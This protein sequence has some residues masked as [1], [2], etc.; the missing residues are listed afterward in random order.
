MLLLLLLAE[1]LCSGGAL[2]LLTMLRIT[3]HR[4]GC[5]RRSHMRL[6]HGPLRSLLPDQLVQVH[7]VLQLG[8]VVD[9]LL[10]VYIR[11]AH[12]LL[13][14]LLLLPALA[15]STAATRL[16]LHR[17]SSSLLLLTSYYPI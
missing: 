10:H 3:H 6:V 17:D 14:L 11:H 2:I 16:A 15:V 1:V 9:Q 7:Q 12:L 8:Q 5:L 4:H 13:L